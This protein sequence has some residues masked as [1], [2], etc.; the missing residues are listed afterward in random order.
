ME[1]STIKD[2]GEPVNNKELPSIEEARLN[3][4][5]PHKLFDQLF[6]HAQKRQY[7]SIEAFAEFV[8]SQAV[9][10]KVGAAHIDAPAQM[11]GVSTGKITGPSNSG[12]VQRA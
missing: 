7:P 10:Q 11:S 2:F 4:R 12:M 8:L 3:L 5:I 1:Q 9:N 6:A